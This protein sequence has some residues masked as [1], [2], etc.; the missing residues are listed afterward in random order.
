M[1]VANTAISPKNLTNSF[2]VVLFMNSSVVLIPLVK[3]NNPKIPKTN[4]NNSI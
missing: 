1:R 3:I 4:P 2:S